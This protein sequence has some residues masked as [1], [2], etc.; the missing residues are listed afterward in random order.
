MIDWVIVLAAL[1]VGVALTA[2]LAA[3][4]EARVAGHAHPTT[5]LFLWV[6]PGL[7]LALAGGLLATKLWTVDRVVNAR[8]GPVPALPTPTARPRALQMLSTTLGAA[9][10][11]TATPNRP[12]TSAATATPTPAAP[13]RLIIPSLGVDE[14]VMPVFIRNGHWDMRDLG[15]GVGWLETTGAYPG[16]DLAMVLVAHLTVTAADHGPFAYLQ[17]I[18]AG[19]DVLYQADGI[20]Y[21]YAVSEKGRVQPDRVS[22]LYVPDGQ[23]LLLVTCT[24]W[25]F[26]QFVYANRLMVRAVLVEQRP[27]EDEWRPNA[28]GLR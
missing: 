24:D 15:L 28:D 11:P 9:A 21:R 2:G 7:A 25:D 4:E 1:C 12:V 6:V 18:K 17:K 16:D 19:A 13:P 22:K 5:R 20:E 14:A 26:D 10:N 23:S 27:L 8:T 3:R